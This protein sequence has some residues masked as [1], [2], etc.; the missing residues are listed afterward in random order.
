[1]PLRR[2]RRLYKTLLL[3]FTDLAT[4]ILTGVLAMYLRSAL[5]GNLE[6]TDQYVRL[7]PILAFFIG[8][9]A[10]AGLYPGTGLSPVEELRRIFLS[11]T[12]VFV[13]VTATAF[14]VRYGGVYSRGVFAM[15]WAIALFAVQ[16]DRWFLRALANRWRMWGEPVAIIGY[17]EQGREIIDHLHANPQLGLV[18]AVIL[19]HFTD[20]ASEEFPPEIPVVNARNRDSL[21]VVLREVD[22]AI[23]VTTEIPQTLQ[24]EVIDDKRF[25]FKRLILISDLQRVSSLGVVIHDLEGYLGLEVRQNL[26]SAFDQAVKRMIDIVTMSIGGLIILPLLLIIALLIKLDSP[27]GVLYPQIRIGRDGKRFKMWKFRTMIEGADQVL[28]EYLETHPTARQEW[29]SLQKIKNDPRIT[30]IGRILRTFSL[31][32]LPQILNILAGDMSLVGP[33]PFLPEQRQIYGK[34]FQLYK[35]VRPGLTGLW[36]VTGRNGTTFAERAKLDEFYVR[37]WSIW[38]DLYILLR[39]G[40]VVVSRDGAY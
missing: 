32:E 15:H 39:T 28:E 5:L 3:V 23:M 37:N 29:D 20:E 2:Y 9:Y 16:L 35:Q 1:M 7:L 21:P 8:V 14:W 17:G 34:T 12:L 26:L 27:G 33:R 40:W 38:L 13:L 10:L 30:R 31:D 6:F 4:L 11:T 18:P 19:G 25:N 36:Q 24:D 22:T